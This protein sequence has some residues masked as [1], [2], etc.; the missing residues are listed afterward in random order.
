MLDQDINKQECPKCGTVGRMKRQIVGEAIHVGYDKKKRH[1]FREP[2]NVPVEGMVLWVM[3]Y[4]P[5]VD[6]FV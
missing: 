4:G 1:G 6:N 3:T 2:E 5:P